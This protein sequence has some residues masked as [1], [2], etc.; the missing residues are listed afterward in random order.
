MNEDSQEGIISL[1]NSIFDVNEFT[2][3][4]FTL[5]FKIA[6]LEFQTKFE[7]LARSLENKSYACRLL[8]K[9][10]QVYIEIQKF[11]VKKP[12]KTKQQRSSKIE[13]DASGRPVKF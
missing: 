3:T 6:N 10:D 7:D 4:E 8:K 9:N 5:E 11:T 1:V 13:R 2:K 12:S